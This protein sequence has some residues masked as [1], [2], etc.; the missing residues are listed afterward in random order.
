M[1][2]NKV[3]QVILIRSDLEMS[4][5]EMVTQGAHASIATILDKMVTYIDH[6]YVDGGC[7]LTVVKLKE[8]GKKLKIDK[9]GYLDKWINYSFVKITLVID[10]KEELEL[11]HY[12]A[13]SLGI[14]T[15]LIDD[16][17]KSKKDRVL[18]ACAIGPYWS[19]DIDKLTGNLNLLK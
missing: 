4:N 15:S 14:P 10:S 3:K 8:K 6:D 11:L 13:K 7:G 18:T 1:E 2:N 5:G 9:N 12:K 17:I 19:D 16:K